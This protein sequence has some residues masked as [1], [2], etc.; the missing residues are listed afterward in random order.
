MR[1]KIALINAP[2]LQEWNVNGI[3][4]SWRDGEITLNANAVDESARID[5]NAAPDALLKNALIVAGGV[6]E[7]EAAHLV[8]AIADWRDPDDLKRLNGAEEADYRAAG[9]NYGPA[10][11]PFETVGEL[12]RVLGIT[13]EI[14]AR[15]AP[16]LTVYSR[17]PGINATTAS[18]EVLLA[19]PGATEDLVDTYIAQRAAALQNRLPVP[20]FPPAS[21][22]PGAAIPVWRIH[23]E[24]TAPDGVTFVR[25]AVLRPSGD[26]RRPLVALAWSEGNRWPVAQP[27]SDGA[28]NAA[29]PGNSSTMSRSDGR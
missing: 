29:G 23:A 19:L 7:S 24:A 28:T 5:L 1:P 12:A 6:D 3:P 13:P 14:Y 26:P 25:E 16:L 17:Q 4:H 15:V 2:A 21:A 27:A 10:N 22:F 11:A 9:R 20:N 18:R 8:D